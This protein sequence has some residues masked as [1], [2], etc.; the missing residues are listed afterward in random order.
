MLCKVSSLAFYGLDPIPVD[1][2]VSVSGTG[3]PA[4][5]I[6]G[7]PNKSI[8]ESKHRV[9]SAIR[10]SG[11]QF[12]NKKITVNL[13]PAD[14]HKVGSFYDL[15]IATGI[16]CA[17]EGIILDEK[18]VYFGELSLDGTIR[19]TKGTLNAALFVQSN[20]Y[21]SLIISKA[22]S[23]IC[24]YCNSIKIFCFDNLLSVFRHVSG[25]EIMKPFK[26][27]T[28]PSCLEA[29]AKEGINI[30]DIIGQNA[31][32][33][34][35]AISVA[36]GHHMLMVGS[37]G[38]GKTLLASSIN[39]ILPKLTHSDALE[40]ARI[41][42]YSGHYQMENPFLY[43]P[44]VRSPHHSTTYVGMIGGGAVPTPGEI[45]LAHL[46]FLFM[47]EFCEFSR[48]VIE[49]LR[50]PLESGYISLARAQYKVQFPAKFTMLAATNP[51]KCGYK[52][53]S[54]TKCTCSDREIYS[55]L[56]KLSGP[57]LDRIDLIAHVRKVPDILIKS[58]KHNLITSVSLISSIDRARH[59]QRERFKDTKIQ[60]N[61]ELPFQ[62]LQEYASL[63]K[64][65]SLLL[66]Q[67]VAVYGLSNRSCHKII[68]IARTIA[69]MEGCSHIT[70]EHMLE[71]IQYKCEG[72]L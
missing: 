46:G 42:S 54:L 64:S 52:G 14:I 19:H 31:V 39:S 13:A 67:A 66:K 16:L 15:A 8:E 51:C 23:D 55:Y 43:Y 18:V 29:K 70:E 28:P 49:V 27:E 2:E 11:L 7:L 34:M 59:I 60:Y 4:F 12:P 71:S 21:D 10:Q 3:L 50:Q 58:S 45:T 41:Y 9:K 56:S 26:V 72:S 69:D 5:D 40:V 22:S 68:K 47:D 33:K 25:A 63:T 17:S 65:V 61:R 37:P 32:K 36:G 57:I 20:S 1:V 30:D 53:D 48:Q 24:K 62:F 38:V 44:P 35:L 6:V